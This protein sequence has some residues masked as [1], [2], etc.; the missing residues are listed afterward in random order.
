MP[1]VS[2]AP[3]GS[4]ANASITQLMA[5][6]EQHAVDK[7]KHQ[8]AT[9]TFL[10]DLQCVQDKYALECSKLPFAIP[11]KLQRRLLRDQNDQ[12]Q[13][14]PL[15]RVVFGLEAFVRNH[16]E[17]KMRLAK[18]LTVAVVTPMDAFLDQ[19]AKQTKCLLMEIAQALQNE[20]ELSAQ[21]LS[22]RTTAKAES[23]QQS[24]SN[25]S[26]DSVLATKKQQSQ[27]Q[28]KALITRREHER[29]VVKERLDE[30][31]L[32]EQQQLAVTNSILERVIESYNRLI[33]QTRSLI[34]DLQTALAGEIKTTQPECPD[35][36]GDDE[37][38]WRA[39]LKQCERHVAMT[40]W[41]NGFFTQLFAV[42]EN[43]IKRL[44]TMLR[45]HPNSDIFT[46]TG[47][48]PSRTTGSLANRDGASVP[49]ISDLMHFHKLLTVNLV[50]P[51][52]RTLRF[53]KQKQDKIRQELLASLDETAK[54]V[55]HTRKQ[56]R[57]RELKHLRALHGS[58]SSSAAVAPSGSPGHAVVVSVATS[59]SGHV[60][61][62]MRLNLSNFGLRSAVVAMSKTMGTTN[63]G[64]SRT[65]L[66]DD[67]CEEPQDTM[68][69]KKPPP[70]VMGTEKELNGARM[71]LLS[72]QRN[73][74]EQRREIVKTLRSTSLLGVKT[75]E[76]MVHDYL[77][78]VG[79][80][81]RA[82]QVCVDKYDAMRAASAASSAVGSAALE[83]SGCASSQCPSKWHSF[84]RFSAQ[85]VDADLKK[86]CED[87]DDD[88]EAGPEQDLA[89]DDSSQV[90]E[91]S[92]YHKRGA[93]QQQQLRRRAGKLS[94][95]RAAN[96]V[97]EPRSKTVLTA[98]TKSQGDK[99]SSQSSGET[100]SQSGS[101]STLATVRL[102]T[103][104]MQGVLKKSLERVVAHVFQSEL[105]ALLA[106]TGVL[107]GMALFA[108]CLW[109][110]LARLQESWEE[111]AALQRSSAVA[112]EHVVQ[113]LIQHNHH[114]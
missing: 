75:M 104:K 20:Q 90:D 85:E 41:L 68:A 31:H 13:V 23:S 48:S 17:A 12:V 28:L 18:E 11:D 74:V 24:G 79:I 47:T 8:H 61:D 25:Q 14:Q 33:T 50:D 3:S 64:K 6:L 44:Q 93:S 58:S 56:V 7:L 53:S 99:S 26:E 77:K 92:G 57:E 67:D 52:G 106:F 76:L 94:W 101:S 16:N 21:C 72:L 105:S 15:G 66:T 113:L 42:E 51:I 103:A 43:M 62:A 5:P 73:E 38:S 69:K 37:Q 1:M 40:E 9:S 60:A 78:H 65:S 108:L 54:L 45:L 88:V 19:Q 39:F 82:L 55:Q 32:V 63:Q 4:G 35:N 36:A 27:R 22:L 109:L 86:D 34:A 91:V 95:E 100:T 87:G 59:F 81:L 80:A 2:S 49:V 111:I 112:F 83:A 46:A 29:A 70:A 30:L 89:F 96:F 84:I 114:Q 98:P 102:T 110:H 71:Y 107:A 97:Q 10:R